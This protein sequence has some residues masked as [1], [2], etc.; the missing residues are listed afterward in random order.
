MRELLGLVAA[1]AFVIPPFADEKK[2]IVDTSSLFLVLLHF[3][4]VF[5]SFH[6]SV[7]FADDLP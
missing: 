5:R 2:E 1:V 4:R 6:G 7:L 3:F